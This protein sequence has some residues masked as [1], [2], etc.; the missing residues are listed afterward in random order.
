MRK[1]QFLRKPINASPSIDAHDK[2]I[3]AN[4]VRRSNLLD[5]AISGVLTH[6]LPAD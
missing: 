5:K 1:R 2:K 4:P 6:K 3:M